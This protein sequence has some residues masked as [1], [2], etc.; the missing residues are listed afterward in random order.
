M[1]RLFKND[2]EKKYDVNTYITE[3]FPLENFSAFGLVMDGI[4]FKTGEHAF[5]YLKF[6]D[7]K[8]CDEIIN[9]GNPYEARVL[10]GKYKSER[11][12]NWSE[13]KYDYLEKVFKLK[14]EQNQMVKDA[15]LATKDYLICEYCVDEDTEWG[16]DK[17]GNG[18]NRL[19]KAW[20]NVRNEISEL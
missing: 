5:Q 16:L 11:I 15:L 8:I 12:T 9:C 19:G 7:K 14:V 3:I 6:K 20:M 13:V 1:L 17:N 2:K 4:Y 18:E 10:G